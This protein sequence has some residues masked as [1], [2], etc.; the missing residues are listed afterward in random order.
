MNLFWIKSPYLPFACAYQSNLSLSLTTV[1]MIRSTLEL[2][3]N[4]SKFYF[5]AKLQIQSCIW[6]SLAILRHLGDTWARANLEWAY[7]INFDI[8]YYLVDFLTIYHFVEM[9]HPEKRSQAWFFC[10]FYARCYKNYE[11]PTNSLQIRDHSHCLGLGSQPLGLQLI[12]VS[13]VLH[14]NRPQ[15]HLS[16]LR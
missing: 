6:L 15:H 12:A 5:P 16:A 13:L 11:P 10:L 14:I 8:L 1:D 7:I 9:S 4:I 3:I 2:I